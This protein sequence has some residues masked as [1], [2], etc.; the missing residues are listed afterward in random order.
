MKKLGGF[1]LRRWSVNELKNKRSSSADIVTTGEEVTADESF[2]DAR[3]AATLA[4]D[5]GY[6][7]EVDSG[8][9]SDTAEDVLKFV[10]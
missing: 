6:L 8:L 3:L 9:T 1:S 4:T 2:E 7:R 5:D 10:D